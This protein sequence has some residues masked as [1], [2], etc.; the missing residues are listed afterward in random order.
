MDEIDVRELED[1]ETEILIDGQ[2][3]NLPVIKEE[4]ESSSNGA[5]PFDLYIVEDL[6]RSPGGLRARQSL[7]EVL[8]VI[9]DSSVLGRLLVLSQRYKRKQL[10]SLIQEKILLSQ[11]L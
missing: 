4:Q 3:V 1:V 11:R 2:I 9:N 8:S 10:E 6:I 5:L 7:T